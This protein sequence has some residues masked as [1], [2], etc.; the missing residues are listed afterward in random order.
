VTA[1]V[2]ISLYFSTV[3]LATAFTQKIFR[4]LI[5]VVEQQKSLI[6]Q[7]VKIVKV[8]KGKFFY[9]EANIRQL[10]QSVSRQLSLHN[11]ISHQRLIISGGTTSGQM[12]WLE[13]PPPWLRPAYCFAL[14]R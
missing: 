4:L 3:I 6:T 11:R 13:D 2:K 14:L 9:A 10:F 8:K 12:T 5:Q 1:T 7:L